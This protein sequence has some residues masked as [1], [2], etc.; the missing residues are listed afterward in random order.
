MHNIDTDGIDPLVKIPHLYYADPME[1][2]DALGSVVHPTTIVDI[3]STI[4]RK[5]EM[6]LCHKSQLGWLT[7][8]HGVE[9]CV[10][11]MRTLST[12]RGKMVGVRYAEG[13][14]QHL[15]HAYPQDNIL[16]HE[17]GDCVHVRNGPGGTGKDTAI[18]PD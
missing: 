16:R 14:R 6:F 15:G 18:V 13:F 5:E 3:S 9:D 10:Q 2:K 12:M 17:L 7:A 4:G 1:G 8:H 11:S